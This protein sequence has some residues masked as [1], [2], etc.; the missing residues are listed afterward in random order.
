MSILNLFR[1]FFIFRNIFKNVLAPDAY[2][3]AGLTKNPLWLISTSDTIYIYV[4]TAAC[5][6][7]Y[8]PTYFTSISGINYHFL[9]WGYSALYNVNKVGFR[10]YFHSLGSKNSSVMLSQANSYNWSINWFGNML[11]EF[12]I[13]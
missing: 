5:G 9:M 1:L 11:F 4:T 13:I 12:L 3:C 10:L 2:K 8:T 6:F 7:N